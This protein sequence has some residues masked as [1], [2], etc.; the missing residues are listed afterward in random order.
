MGLK[1][2]N[3]VVP[4]WK[5]EKCKSCNF[6]ITSDVD[7]IINGTEFENT[8]TDGWCTCEKSDF[9]EKQV[10]TYTPACKHWLRWNS[11]N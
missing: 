6:F 7:D 1:I 11:K 4:Q 5:N 10:E 8:S 2:K 3:K 9:F